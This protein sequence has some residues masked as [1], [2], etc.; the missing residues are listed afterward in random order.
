MMFIGL[1]IHDRQ[2]REEIKNRSPFRESINPKM[3]K[4]ILFVAAI[5]TIVLFASCNDKDKD[6]LV[7]KWKYQSAIRERITNADPNDVWTVEEPPT[8]LT[9]EIREFKR[10]GTMS[11]Y[12]EVNYIDVGNYVET[13]DWKLSD[14]RKTIRFTNGRNNQGVEV[15][16][17]DHDEKVLTL[18]EDQLITQYKF[19]GPEYTFIWT[20]TFNRLK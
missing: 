12:T 4:S 19:T 5:C 10:D 3:K 6:G 20:T 8:N 13:W 2:H 1:L 14:D 7:G 9:M 18:N 16:Y 11:Q 15:G 17:Q